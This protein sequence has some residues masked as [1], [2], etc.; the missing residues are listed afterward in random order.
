MNKHYIYFIIMILCISSV[1]ALTLSSVESNVMENMVVVSWLT[2]AQ[3]N[4]KIV[5][6]IDEMNISD[7]TSALT[8]THALPLTGLKQA[9]TY[10]FKVS[11]CLENNECVDSEVYNFTTLGETN[12]EGGESIN[13]NET[14]NNSTPGDFFLKVEHEGETVPTN[15]NNYKINLDVASLPKANVFVKVNGV[16]K[17][18]KQ[19]GDSGEFTFSGIE[20]DPKLESNEIIVSAEY[21]N[22]VVS[23]TYNITLDL[24]PPSA[25]V[26]MPQDVL[27]QPSFDLNG[28]V[29]EDV[30]LDIYFSKNDGEIK[31]MNSREL[32][33]GKFNNTINFNQGDG[34]Y[35]LKL[36]FS[37]K[38]KNKKIIESE[39]LVDFNDPVVVLDPKIASLTPTYV[40]KVRLS[41][42]TEP[43]ATVQ[44]F[45]NGKTKS[46]ETFST[47][48]VSILT[49][50]GEI[51]G[52]GNEY[53]TTADKNGKFVIDVRL[54]KEFRDDEYL[55]QRLTTLG[56]EGRKVTEH[57][58]TNVPAWK[59]EIKVVA[60]DGVGRHS[61]PVTGNIFLTTCDYGGDWDVNI[62][63]VTP[64]TL[65][66]I[67]LVEGIASLGFNYKLD[68]QG[69]G[70]K[71]LAVVVGKPQ[72]KLPTN[73]V[74]DGIDNNDSKLAQII[75]K[76]GGILNNYHADM[77][78]GSVSIRF[79]R[80]PGTEDELRDKYHSLKAMLEMDISYE[81]DNFG[82]KEIGK[83]IKCVPISIDLDRAFDV[84]KPKKLLKKTTKF[85]EWTVNS[86]DKVLKYVTY[87]R[88]ATFFASIAGN[89]YELI[90]NAKQK[91]ACAKY[92]SNQFIPKDDTGKIITSPDDCA[93]D[94]DN[95]VSCLASI[96][97][98]EK[99]RRINHWVSDRMFCP[100]IPSVGRYI[101][102]NGQGKKS[103]YVYPTKEENDNDEA[104]IIH[105]KSACNKDLLKLEYNEENED[106]YAD[107]K[108]QYEYE[109][110]PACLGIKDIYKYSFNETK[111]SNFF[112]RMVS[113]VDGV[114]KGGTNSYQDVIHKTGNRCKDHGFSKEI[115]DYDDCYY[116]INPK[117]PAGLAKG[118]YEAEY[119][120][121]REYLRGPDGE[122]IKDK[123]GKGILA[124]K[125]DSISLRYEDG[126]PVRIDVKKPDETEEQYKARM[127]KRGL[128]SYVQGKSGDYV[129]DPTSS[130]FRS[131]QCGCVPAVEEYIKHYRNMADATRLCFEDVLIS[132]NVTAGFCKSVITEY[133]C[134]L[135][136]DAIKCGG[137]F[138]AKQN[139]VKGIGQRTDGLTG[140]FSALS[141]AGQDVGRSVRGRYGTTTMFKTM[142]NEKSLL[143]SACYGAFFGDW[144]VELESLSAMTTNV[145]PIKSDV[146]MHPVTREFISSSPFTGRTTYIYHVNLGMVSGANLNFNLRLA[147]S[148]ENTCDTDTGE[149]DCFRTGK[150][151]S[152]STPAKGS[153]R[154]G[155]IYQ[156]DFYIPIKDAGVRYDKA[157]LTYKYKNNQGKEVTEVV[158]R[159][160]KEVGGKPP[161]NCGFD[162]SLGQFLCDFEVGER[163]YASFGQ[164]V[165]RLEGGYNTRTLKIGDQIKLEGEVI[166]RSPGYDANNPDAIKE[167]KNVYFLAEIKTLDGQL[168][169]N[170][171]FLY[172][173]LPDDKVYDLGTISNYFNFRVKKE[174]FGAS[175][176]QDITGND[177]NAAFA[178]KMGSINHDVRIS[179]TQKDKNDPATIQVFTQG[180]ISRE[181][182]S[183]LED[184]DNDALKKISDGVYNG[185]YKNSLKFKVDDAL[186][187][188]VGEPSKNFQGMFDQRIVLKS[189]VMAPQKFIIH[190]SLHYADEKNPS[191][192]DVLNPIVNGAK[193]E[194]Y[195]IVFNAIPQNSDSSD[196]CANFVSFEGITGSTRCSCKGEMGPPDSTHIYCSQYKT[197][198]GSSWLD[199]PDCEAIRLH[200]KN[201]QS[202]KE[203]SILK[204]NYKCYCGEDLWNGISE[205]ANPQYCYKKQGQEVPKIQGWV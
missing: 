202:T 166:K 33:E 96:T 75:L 81:F 129:I 92:A 179:F 123:E 60:I 176:D 133:V 26:T 153:L 131:V 107:C 32:S 14:S 34:K 185:T 54:S 61:E 101:E 120:E 72:I 142:F 164:T 49:T 41:G 178:T 114:C 17:R 150:E 89:G 76:N 95:C 83:Q 88:K 1:S 62:E 69:P 193:K 58:F 93:D 201:S 65:K 45:V 188:L 28:S 98:L 144:N 148:A 108:A 168:I 128:G 16:L 82:T 161:L 8:L 196:K 56:D 3:S 154:K 186:I 199:K 7:E 102:E 30:N 145:V 162:V 195:S 117:D 13:S 73:T 11:S 115:E 27:L 192:P 104:S 132:E 35:Y 109:W 2:D 4:S 139:L 112:E 121:D 156:R 53:T 21:E 174:W 191:L 70:D 189:S 50:F 71:S 47:D 127:T 158:D 99:A 136:Y 170:D 51:I 187:S 85:L 10:S 100:S 43:G 91:L 31:L 110:G 22:Q 138:F 119:D 155:E 103:Y 59:N 66:P 180:D 12:G 15:Y 122:I 172:Y 94:D 38:A 63:Q 126:K 203:N 20:M 64:T 147:C 78:M 194:E 57:V 52:T 23:K 181:D 143:H 204:D 183:S 77:N 200:L 97:S 68:W 163:G 36:I 111:N 184:G 25:E 182:G 44:V 149:C 5:Y 116:I 105:D 160:I 42:T 87:V 190:I 146:F 79:N 141:N 118:I 106:K 9:S 171:N 67:H 135:I 197:I 6:G 130:F 167:N 74:V 80:Y 40:N 169:D 84:K 113:T 134:D 177:N 37:D 124:D 151:V 152:V 165:P 18:H 125:Y 157:I 24:V 48:L 175:A 159:P 86:T 29:S 205:P 137:K 198:S 173:P 19:L 55:G 46:S 140:F 39:F 90:M